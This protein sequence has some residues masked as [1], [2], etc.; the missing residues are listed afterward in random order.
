MLSDEFIS[1]LIRTKILEIDNSFQKLIFYC[2]DI[3]LYK[4]DISWK[5]ISSGNLFI[6]KNKKSYKMLIISKNC[7]DVNFEIKNF[8]CVNNLLIVN[9]YGIWKEN[10]ENVYEILERMRIE[11]KLENV[12]FLY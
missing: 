11:K 8:D 7:E 5:K 10:I 3:F 1:S 6:Y 12:D 2:T 4:F 9:E